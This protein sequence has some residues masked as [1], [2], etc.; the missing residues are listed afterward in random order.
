MGR[1]YNNSTLTVQASA[2]QTA[3]NNS[4]AQTNFNARGIDLYV[5]VTAASGTSPTLAVKIQ[6]QD[7]V[8]GTWVDLPGAV[9]ANIT[10][11]GITVLQVYPGVAAVANSTISAALPRAWRC[12]STIAGTSP[13]FTYSIGGAYI[14]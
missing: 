12:V 6:T 10:A 2:A 7:P 1:A 4:T 3:T 8:S 13:S 5:N 14:I 11:A 9:T